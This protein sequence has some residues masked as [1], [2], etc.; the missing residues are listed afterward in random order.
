MS[1]YL[2]ALLTVFVVASSSA[3]QPGTQVPPV[4]SSDSDGKTQSNDALLMRAWS[5]KY[6]LRGMYDDTAKFIFTKVAD[7]K[8]E[9]TFILYAGSISRMQWTRWGRTLPFTGTVDWP[10]VQLNGPE[11]TFNLTF[12]GGRLE[13]EAQGVGRECRITLR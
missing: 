13:G 8:V 5:G 1:K 11:I 9:G 2:C 7:G 3:A 10:K 6:N 12:T 4:V